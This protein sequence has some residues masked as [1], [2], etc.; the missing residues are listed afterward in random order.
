MKGYSN[1]WK[2]VAKVCSLV[3]FNL[4]KRSNKEIFK[5]KSHKFK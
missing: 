4:A 2:I 5:Y 1:G 3:D